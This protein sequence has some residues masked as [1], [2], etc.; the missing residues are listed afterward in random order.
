MTL[1]KI[2]LFCDLP[3]GGIAEHAHYQAQALQ[4]EG[5]QVYLLTCAGFLP[6]Q[7]SKSYRVRHWLLRPYADW[8]NALAKRAWFTLATITNQLILAAVILAGRFRNVLLGASSETLALVWVWP[9][10]L[11]RWLGVRYAVN[12]HD[13]QRKLRDGAALLHRWSVKA[14][15]WP[16]RFGLI[17]ED[18][19]AEQPQIPPHI[20]C[21]RVPYGCYEAERAPGDGDG[22]R[23]ELAPRGSG[24]HILLAFGYIADRKNIESCVRAVARVPE[25]V[26]LV[27]G[28]VASRHDKPAQFYRDLAA[29]LGCAERVRIDDGFV[30][31][32]ALRAYF[33]A[34]DAILLTYKAEFVSQSG[35]LLLASNWAKP[36]LASSGPGPLAETVARFDLGPV[37]AADDIAAMQ[38]AMRLLIS[39]GYPNEGW[40]SFR[41]HASW[42][43]N[44]TQLCAALEIASGV[45]KVS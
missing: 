38:Q 37:I 26:L 22:L 5:V 4:A 2:L 15:F 44:V 41:Q 43:R 39:R 33:G 8:R 29:E 19:D 31:D 11:L 1:H 12:I 21:L 30:P 45:E 20:V 28:R 17:H 18:F 25:A 23:A 27:A 10:L 36:V 24:R 3:E 32:D 34:A 13:P 9:H 42:Q 7:V 40:E 16:I 14:G 6:G 35:V